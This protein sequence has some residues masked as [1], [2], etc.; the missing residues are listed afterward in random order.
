MLDRQDNRQSDN[1][2]RWPTFRNKDFLG[3]ATSR[4]RYYD[5][6]ESQSGLLSA[7][8]NQDEGSDSNQE[9]EMSCRTRKNGSSNNKHN[10]LLSGQETENQTSR[11]IYSDI[12]RPVIDFVEWTV[13]QGD[14]L[15]SL[16]LKSGCTVSQIKR[17]NN[18]FTEQDFY[19]LKAIRI[20][21]KKYGILSE[22]LVNT[23][24]AEDQ[25]KELESSSQ[26]VTDDNQPR[27][28]SSSI[29]KA[30]LEE[31]RSKEKTVQDFIKSLDN[32]LEQIREKINRNSPP[33]DSVHLPV[34]VPLPK[35]TLQSHHNDECG[36]SLSQVL[37]LVLIVCILVPVTYIILAE[38]EII[39][40]NHHLHAHDHD[41]Q[42]LLQITSE[43]S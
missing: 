5:E 10:V 21:I 33:R 12:P 23:S 17:I 30:N 28:T 34:Q 11:R 37:C 42:P 2:K 43:R 9:L 40:H 29:L 3:K 27:L 24:N 26:Q 19:A 22:I 16:S 20:P 35:K 38:E 36:L 13:N 31:P 4:N 7:Q 6:D 15:E 25:L 1:N 8:Y 32:N 41:H 39:E 18:L 14:T